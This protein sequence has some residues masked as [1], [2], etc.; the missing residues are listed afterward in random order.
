MHGFALN[1]DVDLSWYDC[2]VP[3]GIADAGVTTLSEE[4]GRD[5]TVAE[6][7]PLVEQHLDALLA[8][9]PY[10]P[11][12]DY[13]PRPEPGRRSAAGGDLRVPVRNP[14]A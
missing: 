11:T 4:L 14:L 10:D 3:C 12:P 1:C 6:V 2:F 13:E 5:V 7:L 8:W 9:A